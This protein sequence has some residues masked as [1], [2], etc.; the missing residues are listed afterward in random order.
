MET[1]VA[2][3]LQHIYLVKTA[4]FEGPL[5]HL[6]TLVESR[7]LFINEVSLAQVTND[8]LA[9]IRTLPKHSLED[10]TGFIIVA[11]TLILIKSRS[12]LP[13]LELTV[14]EEKNI[15]DLETRLALYQK[16]KELGENLRKTYGTSRVHLGVRRLGS[17][18]IWS[19]SKNLS[20][21]IL[22]DLAN[23]LL[24]KQPVEAAPHP[25][26]RVRKVMSIDD[27]ITHLTERIASH[28][29]MSFRE[30]SNKAD[31]EDSHEQKVHVIISFLAI[32][33]LVREGILDALQGESF[34]DITINKVTNET[35]AYDS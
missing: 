35:Q 12:L 19:P 27:M 8:Y 13:N 4:T 23:E 30:I 32:L 24:R 3:D 1:E 11:A 14:E 7:K 2:V 6:L 18:P 10:V 33:E 15:E 22:L 34:A 29:S 17:D 5:E 25:E 20:R 21:A 28:V 9:Y 31:A 26:V 16:A